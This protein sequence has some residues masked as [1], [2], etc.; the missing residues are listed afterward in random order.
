LKRLWE[1]IEMVWIDQNQGLAALANDRSIHL[2]CLAADGHQAITP[3]RTQ[4]LLHLNGRSKSFTTL[5]LFSR[6]FMR[7]MHGYCSSAL[8]VRMRL[9]FPPALNTATSS[10]V[11]FS[12]HLTNTR[13]GLGSIW[14]LAEQPAP[15]INRNIIVVEGG[16][17]TTITH[18]S[19]SSSSRSSRSRRHHASLSS[20]SPAP[21]RARH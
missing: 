7:S 3:A 16:L 6:A 1:S 20:S 19:S 8:V 15:F 9:R 4:R 10:N 18:P 17:S 14:L 2:P 12:K 5:A 11:F 13:T 21:A